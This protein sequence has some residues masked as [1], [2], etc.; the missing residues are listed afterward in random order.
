MQPQIR[1][2]LAWGCDRDDQGKDLDC[3]T[4]GCDRPNTGH[5]ASDQRAIV[6]DWI[7]AGG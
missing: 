5:T 6:P 1:R 3:E 7:F 4:P 2:C